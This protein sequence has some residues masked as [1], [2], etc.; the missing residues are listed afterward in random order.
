LAR[1]VREKEGERPISFASKFL[2]L[3]ILFREE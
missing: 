2:D 1:N 3:Y